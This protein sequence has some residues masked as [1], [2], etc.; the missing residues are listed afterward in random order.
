[1]L[2]S[3]CSGRILRLMRF[4]FQEQFGDI[5]DRLCRHSRD[6][7]DNAKAIEMLRNAEFRNGKAHDPN[8]EPKI[9]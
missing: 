2:T 3:R 9:S 8:D 7:D 4:P 6:A 5:L 1:M